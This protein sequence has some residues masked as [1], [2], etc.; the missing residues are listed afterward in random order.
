MDVRI[1]HLRSPRSLWTNDG[2]AV[3]R[4]S[5]QVRWACRMPL[6]GAEHP[7]EAAIN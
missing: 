2:V 6:F 7:G 3:G 4:V 1:R 5:V